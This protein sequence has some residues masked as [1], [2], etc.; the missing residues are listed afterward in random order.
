L[1]GN[2]NTI[3]TPAIDVNTATTS[4]G[5]SA[6]DRVFIF[7]NNN[8]I[9]SA[10][11]STIRDVFIQGTGSTVRS[12]NVSVFGNNIVAGTNSVGSYVI[13]DNVTLNTPNTH[14]INKERSVIQG[15][16]LAVSST[17]VF[18]GRATFSST[19]SI[20]GAFNTTGAV[21]MSGTTNITN[22]TQTTNLNQVFT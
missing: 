14:L 5:S 8:I 15:G 3:E 6:T 1:F 11:F 4:V 20:T 16:T 13:G 22:L 18:S 17:S 9:G 2:Y 7:G 12:S 10:T 21:N 19:T